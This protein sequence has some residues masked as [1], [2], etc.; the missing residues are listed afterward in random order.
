[1]TE[2]KYCILPLYEHQ[3]LSKFTEFIFSYHD[4]IFYSIFFNDPA[5]K[6][7]KFT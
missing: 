1:M 3:I 7:Y 6:Q 5:T 4:L 2:D